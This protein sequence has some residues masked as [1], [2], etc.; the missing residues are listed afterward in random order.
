M[1]DFTYAEISAEY[2]DLGFSYPQESDFTEDEVSAAITALPEF[3][4][5]S[6]VAVLRG[7]THS[8]NVVHTFGELAIQLGLRV[9]VT[10]GV[11]SIMRETTAQERREAALTDMRHKREQEQ[12]ATA[13]AS[14][15]S[16]K[17]HFG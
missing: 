13:K 1:P 17:K 2:A 8:A 14:L 12:R 16:R 6:E 9:T 5:K 10:Y 11:L 4:L 7:D 3:H 15:E